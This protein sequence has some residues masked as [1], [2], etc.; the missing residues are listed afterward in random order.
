[1]RII[2]RS[3]TEW[4][5]ALGGYV[6]V[7]ELTSWEDVEPVLLKGGG[8]SST[9]TVQKADPWKGQQAFLKDI[10]QKAKAYQEG[11]GNT[12]PYTGET[13][14]PLAPET[15]QA[16]DYLKDAATNVM[17]GVL[18]TGL[19]A[20]QWGL[21]GVLDVNSNPYLATAVQ[22]AINPIVNEFSDSVLPAI[23]SGAGNAGQ[24]G[25]SR[26]AIA[27]GLAIDRL[28]QTLA[29]TTSGM[30]SD[31]Y[32]RGLDTFDRSLALLPQTLQSTL[33]PGTVLDSI[34]QQNRSYEQ[35]LL[36]AI[37]GQWDYLQNRDLQKLIAYQS[38]VQGNYGGTSTAIGPGMQQPSML[39]RGL[40]GAAMGAGLASALNMSTPWGAGLGAIAG[41]LM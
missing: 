29:D 2:H 37:T 14:A 27:E 15:I 38:L 31:A 25:S 36:N 22:G 35:D 23:R 3:E 21:G 1:M 12:Q 18:A 34:G 28:G 6:T 41:L 19:Q 8:S 13:V 16:Q 11:T 26:Q 40:G 30:Y 7:R 9:T 5:P 17:P 32:N 24:F 39:N 10:F 20:N 4:Q 33:L